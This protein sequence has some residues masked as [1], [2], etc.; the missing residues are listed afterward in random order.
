MCHPDPYT[1]LN[2]VI[3]LWS[4]SHSCQLL[5]PEYKFR[6]T[7]FASHLKAFCYL[8][9]Q[10]YRLRNVVVKYSMLLGLTVFIEV[11]LRV[12]RKG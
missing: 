4:T 5:D 1:I 11:D 2:R 7:N 3:R 9:L 10:D 12:H 8:D 6:K